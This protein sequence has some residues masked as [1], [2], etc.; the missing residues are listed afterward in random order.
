MIG[1]ASM[2]TF[3]IIILF[4]IWWVVAYYLDA[5]RQKR[6]G[7]KDKPIVP[8]EIRKS[9]ADGQDDCNARVQQCAQ[10]GKYGR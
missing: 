5:R 10:L 4:V 9:F 3:G 1:G 6:L 8:K 2:S 7:I